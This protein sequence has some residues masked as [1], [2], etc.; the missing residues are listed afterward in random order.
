MPGLTQALRGFGPMPASCFSLWPSPDSSSQ[1]WQGASSIHLW[2][3]SDL[4]AL[5]GSRPP[6]P[7]R[8]DQSAE[9]ATSFAAH[10]PES[11]WKLAQASRKQQHGMGRTL[12]ASAPE[13]F[14]SVSQT[15]PAIVRRPTSSQHL[16]SC[17]TSFSHFH[18]IAAYQ[19]GQHT[20]AGPSALID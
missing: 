12:H 20:L 3:M 10:C 15:A 9:L 13:V 2:R 11:V 18:P 16:G 7:A 1:Q 14:C 4:S 19:A 5:L 6:T 17:R 8:S